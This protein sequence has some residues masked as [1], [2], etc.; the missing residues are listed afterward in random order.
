MYTSSNSFDSS[1]SRS[2]RS[3]QH[4][5]LHLLELPSLER[6]LVTVILRQGA[7]TLEALTKQHGKAEQYGQAAE[8]VV[9]AIERLIQQGWLVQDP[10]THEVRYRPEKTDEMNRAR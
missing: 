9:Q 1:I 10:V 4:P 7:M 3:R 5:F 6:R 2:G 8:T